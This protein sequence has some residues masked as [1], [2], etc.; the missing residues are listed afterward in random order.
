MIKLSAVLFLSFALALLVFILWKERQAAN[1]MPLWLRSAA[2]VLAVL[3]LVFLLFPPAYKHNRP[4]A[5]REEIT[6]L[7]R[8]VEPKILDSLRKLGIVCYTL[9]VGMAKHPKV[10]HIADWRAFVRKHSQARFIIYG[11]GLAK[12]RLELLK[13]GELFYRG[14]ATPNGILTAHWDQVLESGNA[15]QV[16][17]FYHNETDREARLYLNSAAVP[18]DSLVLPPKKRTRFRLAYQPKQVGKTLFALTAVAGRDTLQQEKVPV[19]LVPPTSLS[20]LLLGASP[21]PD[22]RFLY[23]W[24][25]ENHHQVVSRMRMSKDKFLYAH[26]GPGKNTLEHFTDATFAKTDL[27]LADEA[28]LKQ[29]TYAEQQQVLKAVGK[30]MGLLLFGPGMGSGSIAGRL[31]RWAQPQKKGQQ[32]LNIHFYGQKQGTDLLVNDLEQLKSEAEQLPLL[33]GGNHLLAATKM[34]GRGRITALTL[35]ES[36]T[37]QLDGKESAYA[38]FWSRLIAATLPGKTKGS[39]WQ[40]PAFPTAFEW[41]KLVLT[42]VQEDAVQI[43]QHAYPFLADPWI[44]SAHLVNFWPQH[45]GWNSLRIGSDTAFL[46]SFEKKDWQTAKDYATVAANS[47]ISAAKNKRS[48][49]IEKFKEPVYLPKWLFCLVFLVSAG[50]LWFSCRDYN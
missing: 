14:G 42:D 46:Y 9:D 3:S 29:L 5:G 34:Y 23:T 38:A 33:Y 4:E 31:F 16:Y 12:D 17:G 37:W 6:L 20:V 24:L 19:H 36:Y 47:V 21:S 26:N 48:D 39:Y 8:G 43:Q 10:H 1:R 27:L 18:V 7:T 40:Y 50:M 15:L 11:I 22:Y 41:T 2:A 25:Q 13:A 49:K 35:H 30:G 44:P 28:E 45:H 32:Q